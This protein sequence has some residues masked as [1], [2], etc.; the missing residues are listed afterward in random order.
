MK[1]P[2]HARSTWH[3]AFSVTVFTEY[4]LTVGQSVEKISVFKQKGYVW[5][6]AQSNSLKYVWG[7]AYIPGGATNNGLAIWGG[8]ARK[9]YFSQASGIWKGRDFTRWVHEREGKSVIWVCVRVQ[10]ANRWLLWLYKVEKNVLFLWSIPIEKKVH[11]Q[12]VKGMLSS[13]Q[14]MWKGYH[15]S[16]EGTR[17]G[18]RFREK[19][20]TK[21]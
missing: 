10:R 17:Q 20:Y 12:Q 8:S 14:G 1:K 16:I 11:L 7:V 3:D 15:L 2:S 13:K 5:T 9:G 4:V 18:Y 19:W 21:G 6:R